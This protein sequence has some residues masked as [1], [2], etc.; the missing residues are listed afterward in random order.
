MSV[1]TFLVQNYGGLVKMSEQTYD[2]EDLLQE[3]LADHSE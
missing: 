3:L 2:S 1:G